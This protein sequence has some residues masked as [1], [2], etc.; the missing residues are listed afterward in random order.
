M[1]NHLSLE[2]LHSYFDGELPASDCAR[3]SD[4][5]ASCA[6]CK[7]QIDELARLEGALSE[8]E[9]PEVS[10]AFTAA[11]MSRLA[12]YRPSR[13]PAIAAAIFAIATLVGGTGLFAWGLL[14]DAGALSRVASVVTA[15]SS[16]LA[17]VARSTY[18]LGC[19][20]ARVAEGLLATFS[21]LT[22]SAPPTLQAGAVLA[23]VGLT[24]LLR[25]SVLS[26]RRQRPA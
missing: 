20:A 19:A 24:Y 13:L 15:T 1:T 22:A 23:A 5:I 8:L 21:A 14:L 10:P 25:L 12:P 17:S 4:H 6:Q 16:V 7:G 9:W 11:V 26:Y 2:E 18:L 3:A